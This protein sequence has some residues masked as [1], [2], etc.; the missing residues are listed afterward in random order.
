MRRFYL[1]FERNP[2]N[3][4][5]FYEF[6]FCKV[7]QRRAYYYCNILISTALLLSKKNVLNDICYACFINRHRLL[8]K[9]AIYYEGQLPNRI[10]SIT[11]EKVATSA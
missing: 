3:V 4:M 7:L 2:T 10:N 11:F 5:G 6:L 8:I 1:T 9:N